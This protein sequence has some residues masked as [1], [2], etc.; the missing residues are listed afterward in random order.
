MKKLIILIFVGL[1]I[2]VTTEVCRADYK[3]IPE[4]TP[5]T[6]EVWFGGHGSDQ[7]TSKNASDAR[8]TSLPEEAFRVPGNKAAEYYS[9]ENS[10]SGGILYKSADL[11]NRLHIEFDF[12]DVDD[13]Y[14]DFRYS[15][16]DYVQ[17]RLLPRRFYHNLDNLM[18]YD[19]SGGWVHPPIVPPTGVPLYETNINDL[20]VDDYGLTI[21]IDEYKLRVKPI[22]GFPLHVFS[23]GEYIL[24]EGE[25][26][27]RFPGGD[28]YHGDVNRNSMLVKVDQE[29]QEYSLGANAHLGP[30]EIEG[31]RKWRNF[32]SNTNAPTYQYGWIETA[33]VGDTA[34]QAH[35]VIPELEATTDTFKIHTSHSGRFFASGTYSKVEKTN[36]DTT[37]EA[38]NEMSYGEVVWLPAG[39]ISFTAK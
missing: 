14:G 23:N 7:S 19:W 22:P 6:L 20:G 29:K 12:Y 16:L 15:Y 25:K 17:I 38:S 11:P 1:M 8:T 30:I 36:E 34:Y 10:P 35:N 37:A 27:L 5:D 33:G 18:L 24:K 32:E 26:Q 39:F 3:D 9:L 4:Q 31:S 13:W 2:P 21:D 28:V